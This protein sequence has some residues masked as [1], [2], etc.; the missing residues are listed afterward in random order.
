MIHVP[1]SPIMKNHFLFLLT[2]LSKRDEYDK[3]ILNVLKIKQKEEY[4]SR[5]TYPFSITKCWM[6]KQG[7]V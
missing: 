2:S 7:G 5:E 4:K 3:K 6:E 1:N